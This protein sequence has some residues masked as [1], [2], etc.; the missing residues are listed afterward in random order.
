MRAE[1]KNFQLIGRIKKTKTRNQ[2]SMKKIILAVIIFLLLNIPNEKY[3]NLSALAGNTVSEKR[4]SSPPDIFSENIISTDADEFGS[5]F[6]AD[7]NT[8]YFGKKSPSTLGSSVIVICYSQF[9]NGQWETPQ[10]APFSGRYR[11]FNP[12]I[13]PDG[14]KLFFIS[15]RPGDDEKKHGGD[16]WFV[17]KTK[18]GWSE[19]KNIGAPVNTDGWELG[20]SVTSDG[21]LYFTSTRDGKSAD[22]YRSRLID[23]KYREPENLGEAINSPLDELDPFVAPDESYIL[24]ACTGRDD[25]LAADAGAVY[26]RADLY[27]SFQR[28]GK[29]T[30]PKNLGAPINSGAEESNPFVSRDGKTLFFTSERNFVT[31]P[32]PKPLKYS[33]LENHLHSAANGLG[34]IYQVPFDEVI[35]N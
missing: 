28:D 7:G 5:A 30:P 20:C 12:S 8:I 18:D 3:Q 9:K 1:I 16:I 13:S 32:L 11:D 23:G 31:I 26:P 4:P 15:D 25:A 19:P 10:V 21:T 22:L 24:F 14:S 29:W 2:I 27:I 6:T 34:D 17:E 33:E 35:K